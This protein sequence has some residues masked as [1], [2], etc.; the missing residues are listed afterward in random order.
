MS[1]DTVSP[2][3]EAARDVKNYIAAKQNPIAVAHAETV[4]RLACLIPPRLYANNDPEDFQAVEE[5]ILDYARIVDDL[6]LSVGKEVASSASVRID[7]TSFENVLRT[8]L[9]G[10][11][12]YEIGREVASLK[13]DRAA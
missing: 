6:I 7:I 8:G 4:R 11:A 5:F 1:N 9:E 12:T 2:L 13:E 10:F 3:T